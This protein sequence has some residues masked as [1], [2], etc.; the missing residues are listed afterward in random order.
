MS[1][2][3]E[4]TQ[5]VIDEINFA[6]QKATE[7]ASGDPIPDS[8]EYQHVLDHFPEIDQ[9][10]QEAYDLAVTDESLRQWAQTMVEAS[11]RIS[12]LFTMLCDLIPARDSREYDFTTVSMVLPYMTFTISALQE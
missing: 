5:S 1:T 10:A 12:A 2:L 8:S 4:I 7:L 11:D 3:K 6:L 9:Q